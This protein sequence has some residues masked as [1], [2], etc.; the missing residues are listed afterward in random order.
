MPDDPHGTSRDAPLE[1]LAARAASDPVDREAFG[2]LYDATYDRVYGYVRNRVGDA[3]LA[4]DITE[5]VFLDALAAIS[6]YRPRGGGILAWLFRIARNDVLDHA[7][8]RRDVVPIDAARHRRNHDDDPVE[9][10]VATEERA[11][12]RNAVA[13]L[14]ERQRDVILLRFTSGLTVTE[15]AAALGLSDAAT[16]SLQFRAMKNLQEMLRDA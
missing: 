16:K 15:T 3:H 12:L 1:A 6:R 10:A 2:E 8:R 5:G 11:R 9:R 13:A 4:E 14:P 7:R